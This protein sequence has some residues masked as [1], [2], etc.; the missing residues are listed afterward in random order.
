MK[1][2]TIIAIGA[3]AGGL[4]ALQDFLSHVPVEVKN[5]S[6][7]I[8]QHFSPNYKSMLVQLLSK[9]TTL[10]VVEAL[11]G[12]IIEHHTVYI[13]PAGLDITIEG[14]KISIDQPNTKVGSHPSIDVLFES[15]ANN[16]DYNKIAI[17]LSG[18]GNDG[19]LGVAAIRENKGLVIVQTPATAKYDSMPIAAIDTGSADVILPPSKMGEEIKSFLYDTHW[20]KVLEV[21]QSILDG[22]SLRQI[23]T[24]LS[25]RSGTDFANYKP[26][27][28]HRRISKRLSK[29]AIATMD[30]Y[31]TYI[32]SDSA[33]LD[34][35]FN[36][37]LIGVTQFFRDKEAFEVLKEYLSNIIATKKE[38][39]TIRI[40]V[41]GCATGEEPYSIAIILHKLMEDKN[42]KIN[43]Q[44]F[45]TDID[46][47]AIAIARRSIYPQSAMEEMEAN[48][49]EKYFT[50]KGNYYELNKNIR[51]MVLFSRHDIT[52]NPPFLRLDVVSCRNLLIYFNAELQKTVLPIFHYSL[53]PD[54]Y[55]FLGKS[56]TV[57]EYSNLFTLVNAKYKLF[58]KKPANSLVML[59][60]SGLLA[61][62]TV[63][64]LPQLSNKTEQKGLSLKDMVKETLY[65]TYG[66]PYVVVNDVYDIQEIEGD[67]HLYL[68]F[69]SGT[70]NAN[71]L[72]YINP[73][74]LIEL[75]SL[76][77]ITFQNHEPSVG[78]PK[79]FQAFGTKH[80]VRMT[81]RPLEGQGI[82]N[83]FA[84]ISFEKIDTHADVGII[85]TEAEGDN[86]KIKD[87]QVE[88]EATKEHLQAY[89]EEIETS[90]E[91]LQSLNEEM[92]STN[93]ELQSSNEELETNN[94]ELQST[95]E[96]IQ[97]TYTELKAANHELE[98]KEKELSH[99]NAMFNA[100]FD[101]TQQG[102]LLLES[103]FTIKLINKRANQLFNMIGIE[104][105]VKEKNILEIIPE[106]FIIDFLPYLRNAIL[107]KDEQKKVFTINK[108]T[109]GKV[110]LEFCCTPVDTELI[111]ATNFFNIAILDITSIVE[112]EIILFE[113][114][115]MLTSLLE[116][117]STYLIRVNLDGNYTYLNNAFCK[118]F[119]FKKEDQIGKPYFPTI[120]PDD[121]HLCEESTRK[122][123][124]DTTSVQTVEI[125]K[126]N[127]AGGYF[128]TLW[129]FVAI[130]NK[131]NEVVEIQCMG[132]DITDERKAEKLVLEE[133]DYLEIAI[134]SG[135][136]GI[137]EWNI[138]TGDI[139]VNKQWADL[140]GYNVN[141]LKLTFNSW[142][143]LLYGAEKEKVIGTME[144][145]ING[146]IDFYTL[147]FQLLSQSGEWKWFV[148]T[149]KVLERHPNGKAIMI[150]GIYQ[151]ITFAKAAEESIYKFE[152]QNTAILKTMEEGVI[153]HDLSGKILACNPSAER[154]LGL[155]YEQ[156][157]GR[158]SLDPEWR[159]IKE[160]GDPF[161][162][163]EH[164]SMYT[165]RTG[166]PQKGII[167]GVHK[168]DG[169]LTWIS[170]NSMPI[171]K[172]NKKDFDTV[173]TFFHDITQI[174]LN[175]DE[176]RNL[177]KQLTLTIED[178][179]QFAHIVSHNLRS[180]LANVL[181]V[182]KLL[183]RK[184]VSKDIEGQLEMINN[185]ALK[186]DEV[187]KDLNELLTLRNKNIEFHLLSLDNI[188]AEVMGLLSNQIIQSNTTIQVDFKAVD[189][190]LTVKSYIV[191]I[192]YN[193]VSNAIKYAK[194]GGAPII[195]I[196]SS[197]QDGKVVL[198]I[199]DN[200]KGIDMEKNGNRIFGL[201]QRFDLT[202]E[203]KGMG[204]YLTQT[205]VRVLGGQIKID[206]AVGV[207]TTF[208]I[209]F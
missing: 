11:D 132:R 66:F 116:S 85:I 195:K 78:N 96:E 169:S 64:L 200:G 185:N 16:D 47:K 121:I 152:A 183:I 120:H 203:G 188:I 134:N 162:G 20:K 45:A 205:N 161:P 189:K 123:F 104:G 208:T 204:L 33:E 8:A 192:F 167:M 137:W 158:T 153:L 54:S 65:L 59:R 106:H 25:Q 98:A 126:P 84:M 146:K 1:E 117:N 71:L 148:T 22:S 186:L 10:K 149:G 60:F 125:R 35:L 102:N 7:I 46:E 34:E 163:E 75:R 93:E 13:T 26:N 107:L 193:L 40:W 172:P 165:I 18:T 38:R 199:A 69:P 88:L 142:Q 21:E 119:G 61:Q 180:P 53:L 72:K 124:L 202:K 28:I 178:L 91:E 95:N 127:P 130:K 122:L 174:K 207:G 27:T 113:K 36:S 29:L 30:D 43:V 89:I 5:V 187:I 112:R 6:I 44:I 62:K 196:S 73:D 177:I 191:S 151:D 184:N 92:Q 182:S 32:K 109:G 110:S 86:Q 154:I 140:L 159:A 58:I 83:T 170:I 99:L 143:N 105:E 57:G 194:E 51:N 15:L 39:D 209:T 133:R 173:Y 111:Q 147:E 101:N 175:Q 94:E 100:L 50:Q 155:T 97:I 157:I 138:A 48:N 136:L 23:F 37:I 206:S 176:Q 52:S 197:L 67:V 131:A 70:M 181:G 129:E 168:P 103:N 17:I 82:Q 74:L 76:L 115:A 139:T 166:Q 42:K 79:R 150:L 141:T 160:N 87:L 4:E 80:I 179:T 49:L 144:E 171:I 3:S 55:L 156:M 118:K 128:N 190:I 9:E 2:S 135:R 12:A 164:P 14:D 198:T 31:L 56:E 201:Y 81:V 90:N 108:P 114:D 77:S 63:Q 19:A 145:C 41:P 24:L 68:S